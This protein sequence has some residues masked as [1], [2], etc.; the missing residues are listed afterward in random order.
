MTHWIDRP[1]HGREDLPRGR[2]RAPR[3][4]SAGSSSRGR[5]Y[6]FLGF[7]PGGVRTSSLN[8]GENLKGAFREGLLRQAHAAH[9]G[10]GRGQ[11]AE[12]HRPGAS[13]WPPA[14]RSGCGSPTARTGSASR[15][16]WARRRCRRR[17]CTRS[18]NSG[19]LVGMLGGLRGA[20]DYEK[21]AGRLP[22]TAT[23]GMLAQSAAHVLHD[24]PDCRR[25]RPALR[26]ADAP[27]AKGL[28]GCPSRRPNL[29]R[30]RHSVEMGVVALL[31]VVFL[32]V[33]LIDAESVREGRRL[34]QGRRHHP[35]GRPDARHVQ[36]P[37]PRQRPL[38]DRREPLRRRRARLRR[39][40][41]LAAS[42]CG[43]RSTTRSSTPR[44][45]A[46]SGTRRCTAPCPSSS[47][48]CS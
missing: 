8:M 21:L 40:H 19:Q 23:R 46:P 15:W 43:R 30:R 22:A 6:V 17:T 31:V 26:R 4:S 1:G 34:G 25:Q 45:R 24:R 35:R 20:A 42:R 27:Q 3:R 37:L 11:L 7:K 18:C 12:G 41:H 29:T 47:A 32:T 39:D 33:S 10:A 48:S 2:G 13:T 28:S 14:P 5:D 38:Q 36:L 9:A 16:A 44:P